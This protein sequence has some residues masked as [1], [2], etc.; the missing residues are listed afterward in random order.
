MSTFVE[1]VLPHA[2]YDT[3]EIA[4]FDPV[5]AA[6]L[7]ASGVAVSSSAP[8]APTPPA[9]VLVKFTAATMVGGSPPLYDVGEVAGFPPAISAALVAQGL[10]VLN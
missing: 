2:P 3:G 8:T 9:P 5:T 6:S 10:A 7:I 4:G 1:F